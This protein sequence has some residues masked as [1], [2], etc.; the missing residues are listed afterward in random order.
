MICLALASWLML[1]WSRSFIGLNYRF[2]RLWRRA[3]RNCYAVLKR[4]KSA[5]FIAIWSRVIYR[6][7]HLRLWMQFSNVNRFSKIPAGRQ[8]VSGIPLHIRP[9]SLQSQP[10]LIN[11]IDYRIIKYRTA[12]QLNLTFE[13]GWFSID[14]N[15]RWPRHLTLW[16]PIWDPF[17]THRWPVGDPL[18]T[19]WWPFG[20]PLVTR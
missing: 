9:E 3:Y 5:W 13:M 18:V 6:R 4:V 10:K 17:K 20:D 2:N 16:W 1:F 14:S 7:H 8:S 11:S 19:L 15:C 12:S